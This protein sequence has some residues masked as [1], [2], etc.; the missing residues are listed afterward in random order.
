MR[1]ELLN[2]IPNDLLN[3]IWVN[4]KPETKCSLNKTYFNTFY[5]K[6]LDLIINNF[7]GKSKRKCKY[8]YIQYIIK[9]EMFMYFDKMLNY[10]IHNKNSTLKIFYYNNLK[11]NNIY[12]MINFYI[13]SYNLSTSKKMLNDILKNNNLSQ[14]IK[15]TH[16]NNNNKNIRWI[17]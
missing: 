13:N 7:N 6:K 10:F 1:E 9:N 3:L 16:K 12:D 11:F 4:V 8:N 14:L 15:K 5:E 17:V 2:L